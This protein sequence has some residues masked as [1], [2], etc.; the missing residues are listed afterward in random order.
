MSGLHANLPSGIPLI[1]KADSDET[2]KRI[3]FPPDLASLQFVDF[4][5]KIARSLQFQDVDFGI[6]WEDDDGE[7]VS[8]KEKGMLRRQSLE[9]ADFCSALLAKIWTDADRNYKY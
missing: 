1:V 5:R 3:R 9:G 7:C 8:G 6:I 4:H 2:I